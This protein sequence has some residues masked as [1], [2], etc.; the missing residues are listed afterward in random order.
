[1]QQDKHSPK[2]GVGELNIS[3]DLFFPKNTEAAYIFYDVTTSGEFD[4][5]ALTGNV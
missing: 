5:I 3:S 2:A 4:I 1:M